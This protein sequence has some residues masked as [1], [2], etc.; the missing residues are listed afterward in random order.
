MKKATRLS[1]ILLV[2]FPFVMTPASA[3]ES[4]RRSGDDS[5][6]D[7]DG[8]YDTDYSGISRLRWTGPGRPGTYLDY[9]AGRDERPFSAVPV[10]SFPPGDGTKRM[11]KALILV[12]AELYDGIQGNLERYATDL[13]GDGYAVAVFI[14]T[15]GTPSEVKSFITDHSSGLAG[16]VFVGDLPAAW[17]ESEVWGHEEYPCDLYYM[18]LD[19]TWSDNDSDGMFDYHGAG[20]GDEGPEIFVGHIDASMMSGN[21]EAI[22]NAYF[23]KNHDYRSGGIPAPEYALSYTEDDWAM[24]MDIRTDIQYAYPDFDDIPAPDTNRDDYV[25]NR[26]PNPVYEFIQMCCHSSSVAH[27]FTRGGLAYNY[28]I[29]EAQPYAMF[30]NL[31]ACSSLRFTDSDFLGGSYIYDTSTTSLSVIG[32]TKTGSMLTFWAFYQPFGTGECFGEA[33]RQWFNFLAPYD[34]D[35]TGWH[36]GMTIAGDPFLS[37]FQPAF[38]IGFPDGLPRD[39]LPPGPGNTFTIEIL[40]GSETY[41]PGTGFLYYRFDPDDVYTPAAFVH[42]GGDIYEAAMPVAQP[43]DQPEFYF[44]AESVGGTVITSPAGAPDNVYSLDVCLVQTLFHD[45]FEQDNGWLVE[46]VDLSTGA[47]ERCE[48]NM[49]SGGQFSP[50]ED[51]PAGTGT[52]CFVTGNG[53]PGGYY[54][55]Y[56]VDGGPTSLIS[57]PFGVADGDAVVDFFAWFENDDGDDPFSVDVSS[58]DGITWTNVTNIYGGLTGWTPMSIRVADYVPISEQVRLRIS[59][60]DNPNNSITEAGLD[61][62]SVTSLDYAPLIWADDY[63]FTAAAGCSITVYLDAGAVNAGRPYLVGGGVS[64][65]YP[66]TA[67]PGGEVIPL[68][69]DRLTD[70]ILDNLNGP[71]FR[72]FSGTLDSEGRAVAT[73]DIPGP[74]NPVHAGKTITLAFTLTDGFDVVSNPVLVEIEP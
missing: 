2:L 32:S 9:R 28:Q 54:R 16:C 4:F 72:N 40:P 8:G 47:W 14:M 34:N 45:D 26:V 31:F 71:I 12:N 25:D 7:R 59:T 53:P 61:D 20:S 60:T 5:A 39:Y 63:G 50:V 33:F 70:L 23:D 17:F 37:K 27:Y 41:E 66:G 57:P 21:E 49:T 65:S 3:D 10:S 58:D 22:T 30:F 67:L 38:S 64:G 13:A 18:D 44:L 52:F 6:W 15:G 51:N 19:G 73:L 46:N 48:P 29:Q 68:N 74:V 62:F 43:G 11:A 35:E 36:Y 55:D 1:L 69:R 24:Y 42:Q 56:D